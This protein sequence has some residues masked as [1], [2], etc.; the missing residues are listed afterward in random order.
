MR[1]RVVSVLIAVVLVLGIAILRY[2]DGPGSPPWPP[3]YV[4][5]ITP[6]PNNL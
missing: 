2:G 5:D 6:I 1:K 4:Y 3:I